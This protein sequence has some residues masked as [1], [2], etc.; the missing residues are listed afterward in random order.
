MIRRARATDSGELVA[1][2]FDDMAVSAADDRRQQACRDWFGRSVT[3]PDVL[4][5]VL[6][7]DADAGLLAPPWRS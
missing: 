3:N 4:I 7:A 5:L 6:D 1:L 2:M